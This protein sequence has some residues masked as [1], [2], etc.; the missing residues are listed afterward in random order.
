MA[1]RYTVHILDA[2]NDMKQVGF[3]GIVMTAGNFAAEIAKMEAIETALTPFLLGKIVA[4]SRLANFD[5]N[6]PSPYVPPANVN[7]QNH[8]QWLFTFR[9]TSTGSLWRRKVGTADYSK[10]TLQ[11]VNGNFYV[12]LGA[13]DGLALKTAFDAFITHPETGNAGELIDIRI[14]ES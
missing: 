11:D 6:E 13:G 10:A 8:T 3:D 4:S 12:D 9:E 7:A 5:Q 14:Y 2:D 1:E